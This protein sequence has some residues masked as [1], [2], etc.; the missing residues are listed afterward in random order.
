MAQMDNEVNEAS[1][2]FSETLR[3]EKRQLI[4]ENQELRRKV[5]KMEE[6]LKQKSARILNLY[7]R[8]LGLRV[9]LNSYKD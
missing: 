2:V 9:Q 3:E 5:R 6:D 1:A 8:I 7:D 4:K